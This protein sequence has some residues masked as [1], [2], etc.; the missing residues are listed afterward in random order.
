MVLSAQLRLDLIELLTAGGRRARHW[1]R[2]GV[3]GKPQLYPMEARP[4]AERERLA[5]KLAQP[6]SPAKP[7]RNIA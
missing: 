6:M 7:C 3:A 5:T 1:R 2:I 4:T